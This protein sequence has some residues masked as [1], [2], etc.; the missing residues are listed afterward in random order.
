MHKHAV[1]WMHELCICKI[2]AIIVKYP[3]TM[4]AKTRFSVQLSSISTGVHAG[5][6]LLEQWMAMLDV[7]G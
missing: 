7:A 6:Q 4:V 1:T 2:L 5:V 3:N